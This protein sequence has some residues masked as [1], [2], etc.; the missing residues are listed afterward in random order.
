MA[1]ADHQD[2][3][4]QTAGSK[5]RA[6]D[7]TP[8]AI[9]R[10]GAR[11][12]G[13]QTPGTHGAQTPGTHGSQTPVTHGAQTSGTHGAQTPGTHFA[14][15][16]LAAAKDYLAACEAELVT[17]TDTCAARRTEALLAAEH[18]LDAVIESDAASEMA[19]AQDVY[20]NGGLVL[21]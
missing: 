6:L 5:R 10:K 7:A 18:A 21:D 11:T 14:Q 16:P 12:P 13:A 17:A 19:A 3:T 1:D 20:V 15:T 4:K 9:S 2:C 8:E